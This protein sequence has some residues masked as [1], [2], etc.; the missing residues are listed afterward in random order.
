MRSASSGPLFYPDYDSGDE[1]HVTYM[2]ILIRVSTAAYED[3][4]WTLWRVA[5]RR[6]YRCVST[7]SRILSLTRQ[8]FLCDRKNATSRAIRLSTKAGGAVL[9]SRCCVITTNTRKSTAPNARKERTINFRVCSL[10]LT[11]Q[12]SLRNRAHVKGM[13]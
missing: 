13:I 5:E 7:A 1:S 8:A 11:T 10:H 3:V 4:D 2:P 12:N 6:R 9:G